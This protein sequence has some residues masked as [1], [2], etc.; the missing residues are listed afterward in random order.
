[1]KK[2]ILLFT[3]LI[4][5]APLKT[6]ATSGTCSWHGGVNC[7]IGKDYDGSVICND[8]W[9]FSSVSY[10]STCNDIDDNY[11]HCSYPNTYLYKCT[12]QTDLA[13]L[14]SQLISSGVQ[15]YA[16]G[17]YSSEIA[18]C[19]GDII[20]YN[21][22]ID[23]YNFCE[24]TND[25][26]D[27]N[28]YAN[29]EIR[30][31]FLENTSDCLNNYGN[32]YYNTVKNKC[33]CNA[34]YYESID[35]SLDHKCVKIPKCT[36]GAKLNDNYKCAWT[37]EWLKNWCFNLRGENAYTY[38]KEEDGKDY[39]TCKDGYIL[40]NNNKCIKKIENNTKIEIETIKIDEIQDI[41][42]KDNLIKKEVEKCNVGYVLFNNLCIKIP[43]NAH[44]VSNNIDAWL[45]NEGYKEVGNNCFLIE[46]ANIADIKKEEV[47]DNKIDTKEDNKEIASKEKLN[48]KKE[49]AVQKR[50]MPVVKTFTSF[51]S[52]TFSKIKGWFN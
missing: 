24:N 25:L 27:N 28:Y 37:D 44:M 35:E 34:G 43:E 52:N 48:L 11:N 21:T 42:E 38:H 1:M 26:I 4:I 16:S 29:L 6:L 8:G 23:A 36:E 5:I 2:I 10:N 32:S 51:F 13:I 41:V 20:L 19:E 46:D 31:D 14:R 49:S 47:E 17:M 40:N 3:L 9:H 33:I 50:I 7:D 22:A 12:N 30:M 45:C 15:R 18:A 39:C